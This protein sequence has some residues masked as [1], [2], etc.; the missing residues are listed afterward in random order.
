MATISTYFNSFPLFNKYSGNEWY[1]E[2]INY[3]R[4]RFSPIAHRLN[5]TFRYVDLRPENKDTFSYEY[6]SILRDVGS[7]FSSVLESFLTNINGK[8]GREVRCDFR[9]FLLEEIT[10]LET[11][12]C[13]LGKGVDHRRARWLFPFEG[14]A[15]RKIDSTWWRGYNDVKHRDIHRLEAGNLSNVLYSF[16]A[17]SAQYKEILQSGDISRET[18]GVIADVRGTTHYSQ[19]DLKYFRANI[20][21]R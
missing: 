17:L 4:N 14:F 6:T 15:G 11:V 8:R 20:F 18:E 21:S 19:Q 3:C 13:I 9:T 2:V 16:G 1:Y 12:M 7:V 10:D 5:S